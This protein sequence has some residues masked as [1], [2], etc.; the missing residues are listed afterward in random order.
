M[1]TLLVILFGVVC[2]TPAAA[3]NVSEEAF[4][5]I[6]LSEDDSSRS[7]ITEGEGSHFTVHR[8]YYAPG[9]GGAC[10]EAKTWLRGDRL[11]IS[12]NC[13]GEEYGFRATNRELRFI[14]PNRIAVPVTNQK[15]E[16]RYV[17]CVMPKQTLK[18]THIDNLRKVA[19]ALSALED[20]AEKRA[21]GKVPG[22]G[23][24]TDAERS[25]REKRIFA[26][27]GFASA[28]EHEQV[29]FIVVDIM[30]FHDEAGY[31]E[32]THQRGNVELVLANKDALKWI[33]A[34]PIDQ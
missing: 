28:N 18:Q 20:E 25:D 17:R 30:E 31:I 15:R 3:Q 22:K 26:Q 14:A 29:K 19:D 9:D 11:R 7:C 1:R 8:N 13:D 34:P 27:G 32:R 23:R 24:L 21:E 4:F 10:K 16:D 33:L 2:A 6:W 5:G 12:A